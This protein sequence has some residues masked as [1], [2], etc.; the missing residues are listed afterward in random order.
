MGIHQ[1]ARIVRVRPEGV[2]RVV[3]RSEAPQQIAIGCLLHHTFNGV[4]VVAPFQVNND[5]RPR[6]QGNV[7]LG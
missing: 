3:G 4:D 2:L 7:H 1:A 5:V 6:G